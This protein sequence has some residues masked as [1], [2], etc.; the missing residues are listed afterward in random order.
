MPAKERAVSAERI[1]ASA[2][3][4]KLDF[5]AKPQ[6]TVASKSR[7]SGPWPDNVIR[8]RMRQ[9]IWEDAPRNSFS[10]RSKW[11][12]V[13]GLVIVLVLI[14]SWFLARPGKPHHEGAS[15]A[16]NTQA[17]AP[18]KTTAQKKQPASAAPIQRENPAP[19]PSAAASNGRTQ[20]RVIAYTYNRKEDAQKKV[21]TIAGKHPDLQPIVFSP[22]G[23]SPYLVSIGGVMEKDAAFGLARRSRRMGMPRDTYA[24]NYSSP[25]R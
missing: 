11:L 3:Q 10:W 21:Q 6:E 25:G 4:E 16:A 1:Q 8:S 19:P 12:G 15:P 5:D 17:T 22:K 2:R 20:W 7:E 13:T 23:R 24:Q 14:S 18:P 9:E